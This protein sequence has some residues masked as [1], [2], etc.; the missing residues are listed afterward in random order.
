MQ[1]GSPEFEHQHPRCKKPGMAMCAYNLSTEDAETGRT[2][3]L[4]ELP[5]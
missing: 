2:L 1:T 3:E 5:I 4:A